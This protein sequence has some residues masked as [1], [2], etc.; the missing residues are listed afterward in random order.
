M[1]EHVLMFQWKQIGQHLKKWSALTLWHLNVP[2]DQSLE[3]LATFSKTSGNALDPCVSGMQTG[4]P[5]ALPPSKLAFG[6]DGNA[7][8]SKQGEKVNL[9]GCLQGFDDSNHHKNVE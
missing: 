7:A 8:K 2:N 9:M 5:A 3:L 1:F 4:M 6:T